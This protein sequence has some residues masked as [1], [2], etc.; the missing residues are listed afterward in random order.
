MLNEA[1]ART[2]SIDLELRRSG[3]TE[4][5]IQRK[6]YLTPKSGIDFFDISNVPKH[7]M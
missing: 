3:W 4:G 5:A 1:D 2:K 6:Y 7:A